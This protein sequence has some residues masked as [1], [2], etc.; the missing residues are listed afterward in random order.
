MFSS[1]EALIKTGHEIPD[2]HIMYVACQLRHAIS[3]V[4]RERL[5]LFIRR[6][7]YLLAIL[8]YVKKLSIRDGIWK[9]TVLIYWSH[10]FRNTLFVIKVPEQNNEQTF[11]KRKKKVYWNLKEIECPDQNLIKTTKVRRSSF[12]V[13]RL[14]DANIKGFEYV[15]LFLI[16]FW[17]AC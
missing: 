6:T 10:C 8:W 11:K 16:S 5:P 2:Q 15:K 9:N 17:Y 7:S 3:F 12:S 13:K 1:K 14:L 4:Y